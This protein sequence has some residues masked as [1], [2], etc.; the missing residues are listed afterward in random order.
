MLLLPDLLRIIDLEFSRSSTYFLEIGFIAILLVLFTLRNW[1][2]CFN[3]LVINRIRIQYG[4]TVIIDQNLQTWILPPFWKKNPILAIL[5]S[6]FFST[7]NCLF[8]ENFQ[9]KLLFWKNNQQF[10]PFWK[11]NCEKLGH[12]GEKINH[13]CHSEKVCPLGR[14][15]REAVLI[16]TVPF[17][18]QFHSLWILELNEKNSWAFREWK[19][20]ASN[21]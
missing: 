18:H 10:W 5:K 8:Y 19:K 16:I 3:L 14:F 6:W 1:N 12:F 2:I 9:K 4:N 17:F 13:F 7:K 11:K 21:Y 20:I 15:G